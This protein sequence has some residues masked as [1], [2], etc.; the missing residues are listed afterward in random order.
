[1]DPRSH[2]GRIAAASGLLVGITLLFS[3]ALFPTAARAADVENGRR[4]AQTACMECHTERSANP[5][6]LDLNKLYAGGEAFDGPWGTVFSR[7]LTPDKA[8]GIGNWTDAQIRRSV[9][10]GLD[11]EGQKLILMPW[12]RFRS[13][14]SA[15]LDDVIAYLRTLPAIKND[16]R[17]DKLAPPPAVAGF[18]GSIPPLRN[19][20]PQA[21]YSSPRDVFH[22]FVAAGGDTSIPAAAAGFTAPQ[23]RDSVARGAYLTRNVL[24]CIDCHSSNMA[25][26]APPFFAPNGTP[27]KA[28]GVGNWSK[29]SF[30]RLLREGVKPDGT[31]LS[32]IMPAAQLGYGQLSDED[33]YNVIAY[34]QSIPAVSRAQGQP[35]PMFAPPP[36][37]G[38]PPAPAGLPNTGDTF[39]PWAIGV[40]AAGLVLALGGL[41][42]RRRTA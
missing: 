7:N 33:V 42:V 24:G 9:T 19:V 30:V 32:P 38:G 21:L 28:T 37:A 2:R 39:G 23:G 36:G 10:E 6:Q 29:E 1:M 16:V 34:L 12:E 25:G 20:V 40:L 17:D 31:R 11:D 8:T 14:A 35:N 3:G 5:Y 4:L 26:G 15:D 41:V 27:D 22:D 13:W 18:I